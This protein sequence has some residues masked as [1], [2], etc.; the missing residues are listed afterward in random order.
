LPATIR[1]AHLDLRLIAHRG[2][3]AYLW[4]IVS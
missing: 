1:L 3:E 4:R 2:G